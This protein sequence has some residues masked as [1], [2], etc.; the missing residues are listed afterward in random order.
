MY[1][2]SIL[3]LTI[4][5]ISCQSAP[6]RTENTGT[7]FWPLHIVDSTLYGADGVR[8]VYFNGDELVDLI[9][10]GEE[11]GA[12]RVFLNRGGLTFE[13]LEFPSPQVEDALAADLDGDGR[14][15]VLTFSEGNTREITLHSASEEGEWTSAAIPAS[16]GI[17]W[18]Y[19]VTGRRDPEGPLQIICGSKGDG[20]ILGWLTP[21]GDLANLENWELTPIAPVG[22]IM[23]IEWLDLNGDGWRDI[24]VSDRKGANAAIKWYQN[25]GPA[26]QDR[27]WTEHV[28]GMT[29]REPMFLDVADL[30]GDGMDDIIAADLDAG[31]FYYEKRT[32]D[33]DFAPDSLLFT[34]PDWAG[35]RGKS[36]SCLDLDLDGTLEIVTSFEGAENA[37][38]LIYSKFNADRQTWEHFPVSDRR[39]IKYDKILPLDIDG[40]GD[41]DLFTTEEREGGRGL[42]VVW[43]QNPVR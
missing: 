34:Y 23:S 27:A 13:S 43:Y 19:G 16:K 28:V 39:G 14:M 12:T 32:A 20:A 6:E 5:V 9:S 42:G 37:H 4:L 7:P 30:N 40:D 3:L 17:Q 36:V 21:A 41:L 25:P 38:G 33:G 15:E 26:N 29:G 2:I 24:L 8:A 35:T 11:F 1:R 10:G 22:W 18:M 31:I